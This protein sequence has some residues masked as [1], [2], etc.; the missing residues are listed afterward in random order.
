MTLVTRNGFLASLVIRLV[1]FAPFVVV[2][3]AAGVTTIGVADFTLGTAVGILPKILLTAL[4][5]NSIGKVFTGG[6]GW[7]AIGLLILAGTIW[8]GAGLAARRWMKR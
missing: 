7:T 2:N 1:P 4:A 5:G 6:S 3:L 8:F